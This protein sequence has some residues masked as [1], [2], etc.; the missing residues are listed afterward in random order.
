L[1]RREF[2]DA[3][4]DVARECFMPSHREKSRKLG[5]GTNLFSIVIIEFCMT[6]Q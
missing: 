5:A 3:M 6:Q 4:K 2:A 1:T